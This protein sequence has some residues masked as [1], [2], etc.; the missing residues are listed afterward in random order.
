MHRW[1]TATLE[2]IVQQDDFH[3]SPFREDG[4]TYGTPVWIW[5][6][7]VDGDLCIRA[8]NGSGSRWYQAAITQ[9]G[10]RIHAAGGTWEVA[11]VAAD[12]NMTDRIDQAF[13]EKYAT[14]P[15]LPLQLG[16]VPRTGDVVVFPR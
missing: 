10:G 1:D 13:R 12:P 16:D 9:G 2:R 4:V 6:V 14:S 15:Y 7:D 5:S 3:V 11:F 8:F